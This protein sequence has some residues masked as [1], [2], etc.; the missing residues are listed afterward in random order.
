MAAAGLIAQLVSTESGVF[1]VMAHG[2]SEYTSRCDATPPVREV[3]GVF[4]W[5]MGGGLSMLA[6]V[7]SSNRQFRLCPL[8]V[9]PAA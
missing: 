3:R 4:N 2:R 5:T 6:L 1:R 7:Y 9:S 8:S